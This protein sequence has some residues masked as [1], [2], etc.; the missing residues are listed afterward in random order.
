MNDVPNED[1]Q[2]PRKLSQRLMPQASIRSLIVLIAA[3][4]VT[5]W[6]VRAMFIGNFFWAKCAG[7]ILLTVFGCFVAYASL[8]LLAHLFT[9]VTSPIVS[10]IESAPAPT[11]LESKLKEESSKSVTPD[12]NDTR[13]DGS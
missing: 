9:I 8:F 10:A 3:S 13:M 4:A 6:M 11:G 12:E 1:D 7:V 5:M 2:S